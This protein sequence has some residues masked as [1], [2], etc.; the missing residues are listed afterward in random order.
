M[1]VMAQDWEK[2]WRVNDYQ[3]QQTPTMMVSLYVSTDL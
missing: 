1:S 2:F 3:H